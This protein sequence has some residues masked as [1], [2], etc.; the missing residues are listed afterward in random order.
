MDKDEV[1]WLY[2]LFGGKGEWEGGPHICYLGSMM[3]L[4]RIRYF[5]H[6]M[7]FHIPLSPRCPVQYF[8]CCCWDNARQSHPFQQ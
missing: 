8:V 4:E 3:F 5:S 7:L 2:L 1:D 6:F